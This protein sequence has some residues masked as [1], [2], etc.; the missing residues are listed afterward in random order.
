MSAVV[1]RGQL[2]QAAL[3]VMTRNGLAAGTTRAI[4]AEAGMSLATFHYCFRSRDELLRELMALPERAPLTSAGPPGENLRDILRR[5]FLGQ[6]AQLSD[7]PGRE[8]FLSEL[9]NHALR[10]P[11]LRDLAV[12]Q[13]ERQHQSAERLLVE[14]AERAEMTWRL[15]PATLARLVVI[16]IDGA[17]ATW[18][19]DQDAESTATA[20]ET[21]VDQLS[22]LAVPSTR[23]R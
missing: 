3:R 17:I 4:V 13:Y 1:R 9:T 5:A 12:E 20:L 14:A 18:L 22:T 6:L 2:L 23:S 21:V 15:E 16:M 19:V 7:D 8:L 10:T 11:E